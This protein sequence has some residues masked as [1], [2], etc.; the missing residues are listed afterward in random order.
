MSGSNFSDPYAEL[1][2]PQ[3]GLSFDHAAPPVTAQPASQIELPAQIAM[4][5]QQST[6]TKWLAAV[7]GLMIS[8]F[9]LMA[10][11]P[12]VSMLVHPESTNPTGQRFIWCLV[13]VATMAPLLLAAW[14]PIAPLAS[15]LGYVLIFLATNESEPANT[16]A[17]QL[18]GNADWGTA[19]RWYLQSIGGL[20]TGIALI[21]GAITAILVN[22]ATR[23]AFQAAARNRNRKQLAPVHPAP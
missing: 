14:S 7:A 23:R 13:L 9:T 19:F 15:G 11:A 2:A 16:I 6:G 8:L 4:P 3:P 17:R 10:S 21:M 12:L 5:A 18:L 20:A 1:L 22:R